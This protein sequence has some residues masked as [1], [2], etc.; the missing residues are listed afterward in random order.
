MREV[1]GLVLFRNKERLLGVIKVL[2]VLEWK[3][4]LWEVGISYLAPV[5]N[6]ALGDR[7]LLQVKG[8]F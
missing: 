4:G 8:L 1:I 2:S 3:V 6:Q 5:G 7:L